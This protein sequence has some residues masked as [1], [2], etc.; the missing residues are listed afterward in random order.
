[1]I[2]YHS[3]AVI[4]YSPSEEIEA[5]DRRNSSEPICMGKTFSGGNIKGGCPVG[6]LLPLAVGSEGRLFTVC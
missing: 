1:M 6:V 5:P 2:S 4:Q 3:H